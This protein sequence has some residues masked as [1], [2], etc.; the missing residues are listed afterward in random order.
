MTSLAHNSTLRNPAMPSVAKRARS[1]VQICVGS[2]DAC[3]H[4]ISRFTEAQ[5]GPLSSS[6]SETAEL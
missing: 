1:C 5:T 6:P 3:F 2:R 4:K